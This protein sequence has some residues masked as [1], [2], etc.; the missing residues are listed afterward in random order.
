M[1]SQ[2]P[3]V[4]L[5]DSLVLSRYLSIRWAFGRYRINTPPGVVESSP[6]IASRAFSSPIQTNRSSHHAVLY[7]VRCSTSC[8]NFAFLFCSDVLGLQSHQTKYVRY[9]CRPRLAAPQANRYNPTAGCAPDPGLKTST[10]SFDFRGAQSPFP[11]WRTASGTVNAGPDGAEFT[12]Q[13]RFDAPTIETDFYFFFGKAEVTLKAAPGTGIVSSIV[14]ESDD[15]DEVD[16]VCVLHDHMRCPN[17]WR[18]S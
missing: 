6:F 4:S 12:V 2:L 7:Q 1:R 18:P 17:T 16:W 10:Y 14:I 15:L 11:G 3:L 5:P 9:L 8:C 13:K